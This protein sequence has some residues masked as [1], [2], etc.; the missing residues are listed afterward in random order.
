MASV[1]LATDGTNVV[2]LQPD[3]GVSEAPV[4]P[5]PNGTPMLLA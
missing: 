3:E 5:V 4:I 2:W 1:S